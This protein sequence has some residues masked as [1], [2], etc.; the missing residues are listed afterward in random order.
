MGDLLVL[1]GP[2]ASRPGASRPAVIPA[3]AAAFVAVDDPADRLLWREPAP[4]PRQGAEGVAAPFL[5]HIAIEDAMHAEFVRTM[6]GLK[7]MQ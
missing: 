4:D 7:V 6:D 2:G 1:R 5:V 3:G